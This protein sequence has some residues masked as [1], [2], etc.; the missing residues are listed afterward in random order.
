MR[1]Q[2]E[3]RLA[4]REAELEEFESMDTDDVISMG[5]EDW[6]GAVQGLRDQIDELEAQ[7]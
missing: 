4:E 7:L 5:L 6:E 1:E 3:A 2:V